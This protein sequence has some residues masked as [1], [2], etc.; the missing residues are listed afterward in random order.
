MKNIIK[1]I[2]LLTLFCLSLNSLAQ[3]GEP[4]HFIGT[5]S[6][7]FEPTNWD[8]GVLPDAHTDIVLT[9]G[10]I[11]VVDPSMAPSPI[12]ALIIIN[13]IDMTN[14]TLSLMP[15]STF[16]YNKMFLNE[17]SLFDSRSSEIIG[18][19]LQLNTN[20]SNSN[21]HG[22][23]INPTTNDN[24]S[25][26]ITA[27]TANIQIFLGGTMAASPGN[28]GI[29][30]YAN[31]SADDIELNGNLVINTIYG[32][33]PQFGD[34]FQIITARNSL[35]GQFNNMNEGDVVARLNGLNLVISYRGGD[36]ND[37][38]LTAVDNRN[39]FVGPGNDWM[40]PTNW[41]TGEIPDQTAAIAIPAFMR[42]NNSSVIVGSIDMDDADFDLSDSTI[43]VF[44]W[45]YGKGT[46]HLNPSNILVNQMQMLDNQAGLSFGLGGTIPATQENVGD[47]YF[48]TIDAFDI[49]LNGQLDVFLIYDF[50]PSIGDVF[51]I[52][53]VKNN[54]IGSFVNANE[55]DVVAS[56][57]GIDLRLSYDGG[58][59]NDVILIA[60]DSDDIIFRNGFE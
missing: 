35:T 11:I 29:G 45:G 1:Y 13:N 41:S 56:F 9:D 14:A 59:G 18:D 23:V 31:F 52:I 54:Q 39:V 7:W 26:K 58:D 46:I 4:V 22:I 20:G 53:D 49:E 47:G 40:E 51:K 43:K 6:N 44:G 28:T 10:K 16:H 60:I 38:V 27:S 48:A 32:F 17:G 5:D 15:D 2:L 36:G 8:N 30:H 37:V 24:R 3:T 12:D 34:E 33:Q 25:I 42:L 57:D 50:S 19:E 21:L 55:G